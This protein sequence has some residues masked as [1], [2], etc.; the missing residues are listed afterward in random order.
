MALSNANIYSGTTTITSGTLQIGN[1]GSTG[2]LGSGNVTDNG[3]LTF[4]RT[5]TGL[6]VGNAISG[7]GVVQQ[8]GS[9]T[10]TLTAA[11][12]Y[13]TTLISAGTL[14]IGNGGTAGSLGS[15]AVTDNAAL[16]YNQT[17]FT[18]SNAI[19]GTGAVSNSG[20]T[21]AVTVS[22]SIA[23]TG[24]GGFTFTSVGGSLSAGDNLSVVN[25]TGSITST[26]GSGTGFSINHTDSLSAS[27]TGSITI[28]GATSSTGG[29]NSGLYLGASALT[30]SGTINL[31]GQITGEWG[32][33]YDSN[34]TLHATSGTTTL[35]GTTT[36]NSAGKSPFLFINT[37]TITL[38]ADSG[39]AIVLQGGTG[40]GTSDSIF[41]DYSGNT[42]FNVTGAV[43]FIAGATSSTDSFWGSNGSLNAG[44]PIFN[45]AANSALTLNGGVTSLTNG[46]KIDPSTAMG[47]NSS[48]TIAGSGS[49]TMSGTIAL[50]NASDSLLYSITGSGALTQSAI[51]S[52]AGSLTNNGSGT[53]TLSAANTYGGGTTVTAGTL[54]LSGSG[55]FGNGGLL[56]A[57]GTGTADLAGVGLSGSA[58][59]NGVS[60][61]GNGNGGTITSSTG[62]PT[63][64]V[65]ITGSGN[66]SYSGT[67][68]GSLAFT[69]N[70]SGSGAQILSGPNTYSGVTTVSA[71]TLLANAGATATASSTGVGNVIV[72]SGG[73]LGGTGA[74]LPT[75][76]SG[77]VTV[78][79]GGTILGA[80]GGTLTIN[81]TLSLVSGSIAQFTLGSPSTS[82][83]LIS[84]GTLTPAAGG[85]TTI[86]ITNLNTSVA[87]GTYDLIGF[88]TSGPAAASPAAGFVLGASS[89]APSG[90][91]WTLATTGSGSSG[92][93]DLVVSSLTSL[94]WTGHTNG[95]G[96]NAGINDT[97]DT[98]QTNW[99]NGSAFATYGNGSANVTFTDTNAVDA[100]SPPD[101][102][103]NIVSAGVTPLSVTFSNTGNAGNVGPGHVLY[104]VTSTGS[105]GIGGSTGVA[106][107]GGGTVDFTGI[108]ANTYTGA[109]TIS[110]GSTLVVSADAQL[111]NGSGAGNIVLGGDGN[112]GTLRATGGSSFALGSGRGIYL[113]QSGAFGSGTID[114]ANGAQLTVPG[115]IANNMSGSG[116]LIIASSG[117]GGGSV[118]LTN[119]NNTYSG[120]TTINSGATLQ[121]GTSG[122]SSSPGSLGGGRV[123]VNSAF[124]P[125]TSLGGL[126][127]ANTGSAAVSNGISGSGGSVT[128]NAGSNTIVLGGTNSYTGGTF[129][130]GGMLQLGSAGAFPANTA[131]QIGNTGTGTL[132]LNGQSIAVSSLAASAS[133]PSQINGNIITTSTGTPTLTYAG[134]VS[135][136][137]NYGG[138]LADNG[139]LFGGALGLTVSSGSL[140]LSNTGL[141]GT[142]TYSGGTTINGGTLYANAAATS[143][144][145]SSSSTGIGSVMVNSGGTLAGTGAVLANFSSG[146]VT[147]NSGGTLAQLTSTAT[148]TINGALTFAVTTSGV[149]PI[150]NFTLPTSGPSGSPLINVNGLLTVPT[151][152][153]AVNVNITNF[154][155][156]SLAGGQVYDLLN[157]SNGPAS[158]GGNRAANFSLLTPA[159]SGFNWQLQT[160]GSQLDLVVQAISSGP[161]STSYTLTA[162]TGATIIHSTSNLGLGPSGSG[163]TTTSLTATITNT[164][165]SGAD[166]LNYS[167]LSLAIGSGSD[168]NGS[169]SGMSS[170]SGSGLAQGAT[171]GTGGL[172][173][174]SAATFSSSGKGLYTINPTVNTPVTNHDN[175]P[176]GNA[177]NS[178]ANTPTTVQVNYYAQPAFT[179]NNGSA[180]NNLSGALS[181]SGASYMLTLNVPTTTGNSA[182]LTLANSLLDSTFQ[183]T[184]GGSF[185]FTNVAGNY[186]APST[187]LD[188][189]TLTAIN[190]DGTNSGTQPLTL[191][192]ANA[193][194]ASGA[195]AAGSIAYTASSS[196]SSGTTPLNGGNPIT[197]TVEVESQSQTGLTSYNATDAASGGAFGTG[198]TWSVQNN[199]TSGGANSYA[200]LLSQVSGQT[201]GSG[202][203][204][205][206]YG[207]LLQSTVQTAAQS[208]AGNPGS[209]APLYAQILAGSNSGMYTGNNPATVAMAWRNRTL[210]ESSPLEGGTPASPPL[211]YVGSYLISNVL[212]L[213]GMT[214]T[215]SGEPVQ[216]DPFVLE[217]SY[218]A[219]L[220]SNEA[221][222]AKKGTIYLGW[223]NP[224]GGGT[225]I[226][227]WQKANTG[228]FDSSGHQTG[229]AANGPDVGTAGL[230]YQ[231]SF[232]DFVNSLE[233]NSS[234]S[235]FFGHSP[236]T[237]STIGSLTGAQ[238]NDILGAYGVDSSSGAHDVWAVINHNSQFAVVPEPS[239]LL[240]AALGLAGLAG[241]RR[242]RNRKG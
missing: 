23:M 183:D 37:P 77:S 143:G 82:T 154:G 187:T 164:G 8:I 217:M 73:I 103:V 210:Q 166:S 191:T 31:K 152:S 232:V 123:T 211:G 216:T 102:T 222:Q 84:V 65:N 71:G 52:G 214:T 137:S 165:A 155:S 153:D 128:V 1:G 174:G 192:Y 14:Q 139:S 121:I 208:A 201:I 239:T 176:G 199:A 78:N 215:T 20:A 195:Q 172:T 207:P 212:N 109:T 225:G 45:V 80:T 224:V 50:T 115:A 170:G 178:P 173:N 133:S 49:G 182:S 95:T 104:T 9:G 111:G 85:N 136:P 110:N 100:A 181:V 135:N 194:S 160:T 88:S 13:T 163:L 55:T 132:D 57:Y 12:S 54:K 2:S 148:L 125:A 99:A 89:M 209:G 202:G 142:N 204:V 185:T 92:Q 159:P 67:L 101:G 108:A 169:L 129:V 242:R 10:T 64:T 79:S 22:A 62:T 60:D 36:N 25:G 190:P 38:T 76:S 229:A 34:S 19:S 5:D 219:A 39:A 11:N 221:G 223:L 196:N 87:A 158:S 213:S 167:G 43:S 48:V 46:L 227:E 200:G 234:Y 47:A 74:V 51:I 7:S 134:I 203:A 53:V 180:G 235:D 179:L 70:S 197:I 149:N 117:A 112:G 233:S 146:T 113:G 21:G 193:V 66:H 177:N 147:V 40:T 83:P 58:S 144:M 198:I 33:N 59:V 96:G 162:S 105:V 157:Y 150:A 205:N 186:L 90:F 16:V 114:A 131:L 24:A 4:D 35:T 81:G 171:S 141:S 241:Y 107:N 72:N 168:G 30:T 69:I 218:D 120:S 127:L 63:L 18:V 189:G 3:T 238:L 140:T 230:N 237:D 44:T 116:S 29:G 126:I 119:S 27:G 41:N 86:N 184:L 75:G 28:S 15:G 228:D 32:I 94:T 56:T 42:V 236:Y 226:A 122:P 6:V 175:P 220:L 17:S 93:L 26:T 151:G 97:W 156:L 188:G 124:N 118:I 106:I 240:L 138:Q 91:L 161:A 231:G 206:G 68:S 61:G 130:A 145:I 98:N